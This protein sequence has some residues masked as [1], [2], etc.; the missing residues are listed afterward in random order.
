MSPPAA[1]RASRP[2][3]KACMTWRY[4]S[5]LKINVTLT[6]QGTSQLDTGGTHTATGI[7]NPIKVQTGIDLRNFA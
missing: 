7:N 6:L 3:R 1:S 4:R 5:R 2:A